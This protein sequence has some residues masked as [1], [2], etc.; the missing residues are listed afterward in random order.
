[1]SLL[2]AMLGSLDEAQA[3][4]ADR[5]VVLDTKTVRLIA[6][7]YAARARLEQQLDTAV[8]EEGVAELWICYSLP[9]EETHQAE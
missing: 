8:F 5:G 3:V 4:L 7:R 2:A 1:V 9:E 6:Y